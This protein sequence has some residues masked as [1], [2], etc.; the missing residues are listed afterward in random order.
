MSSRTEPAERAVCVRRLLG[1]ALLAVGVGRALLALAASLFWPHGRDQGVFAWVGDV[2]L[3]GGAPFVDAWEQKGPA[4][5]GTFALVQLLFGRGL[6]GVRVFDALAWLA[7]LGLLAWL[8]RRRVPGVALVLAAATTLCLHYRMG[9]WCTAQP[10]GWASLAGALAWGLVLSPRAALRSGESPRGAWRAVLAGGL[11]AYAALVKLP[12]ALFVLPCVVAIV[13]RPARGRDV[14]C[15]FAGLALGLALGALG[16]AAAGALGEYLEIQLRFNPLVHRALHGR[17]VLE[18]V[19]ALG[20]LLG[21]R[22]LATPALLALLLVLPGER[23]DG[24]LLTSL[25]AMGLVGIA[26]IVL[27]DKYYDYHAAPLFV[28][29]ALLA[30]LGTVRGL[31]LLGGERGARRLAAFLLLGVACFAVRPK[32]DFDGWRAHV[33]G[34]VERERYLSSFRSLEG[35]YDFHANVRVAAWLRERCTP[36]ERVEVFGFEPGILFLAQRRAPTRFGFRHPLTARPELPLVQRY[37]REYMAAMRAAPPRYVVLVTDD[38][39][40]LFRRTS[41]DEAR[42]LGLLALLTERYALET[43]IG[44]FELHRRRG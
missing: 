37:R 22:K 40:N 34:T 16:L 39:N 18:H 23:R 14:A 12:F 20:D 36:E 32:W 43:R 44:S 5:G 26:L 29:V 10:D 25:G 41:R 31:E 2:M 42:D 13:A 11:L 19:A 3:G 6:W 17:G 28:P 38:R 33:F 1:G 15:L 9:Y 7:G 27:Q 21:S 4:A 8:L 30:G 35:D 24:A